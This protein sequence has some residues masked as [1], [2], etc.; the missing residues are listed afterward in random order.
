MFSRYCLRS[1]Y[2]D[3]RSTYVY[4]LREYEKV[5]IV[6]DSLRRESGVSDLIYALK[7]LGNKDI[8]LARW[9]SN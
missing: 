2:D 9:R 7:S 6:T 8:T 1:L 4:N 3:S 5:I